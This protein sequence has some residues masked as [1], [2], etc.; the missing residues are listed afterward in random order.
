MDVLL[1]NARLRA[2]RMTDAAHLAQHMNDRAIWRNLRDRVPFPYTLEDAREYLGRVIHED[3]L[4]A[5]VLEIDDHA[6][7]GMALHPQEDVHHRMLEIGFWLGRTFHGRGIMSEAVPVLVRHALLREPEVNRIH[8][9]VFDWNV[10]SCRLLEKCGFR[11]EGTLRAAI[12]K[13]GE[14]TDLHLYGLLREDAAAQ[15]LLNG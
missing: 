1:T 3:P 13:D 15:A 12:T 11:R 6:A 14:T 7:G 4:D 9:Q 8:A 10:P 2:P 5:F